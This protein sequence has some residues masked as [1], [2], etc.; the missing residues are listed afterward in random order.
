LFLLA[1]NVILVDRFCEDAEVLRLKTQLAL[2]LVIEQGLHI[3]DL[4]GEVKQGLCVD[5]LISG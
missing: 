4:A 2:V 3:S 1:A 5:G